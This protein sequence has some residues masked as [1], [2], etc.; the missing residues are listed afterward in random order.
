MSVF[1]FPSEDR[2]FRQR[3][4]AFSSCSELWVVLQGEAQELEARE[5]V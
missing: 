2:P 4:C 5:L 3:P 1:F